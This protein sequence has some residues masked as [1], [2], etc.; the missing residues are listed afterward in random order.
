MPVIRIV[1]LLAV[2]AVLAAFALS[3]LSP[4][5]SLG[6]LGMKTI[7][8]PLAAWIGIAIAAGALTSFVLQLLNALPRGYSNRRIEDVRDVPPRNRSFYRDSPEPEAPKPETPYTPPPPEPQS[9]R[10]ESDWEEQISEDWEFEE[11]PAASRSQRR[12]VERE[13]QSDRPSYDIPKEPTTRSQTG[14]VYSFG[15]RNPSD[16]GAGKTE[17][18][19]DANYRVIMPPFKAPPP[20]PQSDLEEEEDDNED[21][22]FE[23]DDDFDEQYKRERGQR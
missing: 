1:L 14:S 17:A 7:P 8:L 9:R 21:W 4:L 11:Q 22:G 3:N 10:A 16:S 18:V 23:D 2:V 5:L 15:Y 19:Y 6:F 13:P 12:D 20:E